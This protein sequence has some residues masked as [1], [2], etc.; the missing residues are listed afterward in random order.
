MSVRVG[1]NDVIMTCDVCSKPRASISWTLDGE[2]LPNDVIVSPSGS[3][4]TIPEVHEE[5]FGVYN[6]TGVNMIEDKTYSRVFGLELK[7]NSTIEGELRINFC[8]ERH[9][10]K[11]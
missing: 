9:S 7:R 4:I 8:D 2:E 3:S 11:W 1:D 5:H 10:L 6:C